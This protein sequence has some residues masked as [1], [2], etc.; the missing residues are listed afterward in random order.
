MNPR[1]YR[2]IV[3]GIKGCLPPCI[4]CS[5]N[6]VRICMKTGFECQKFA[7]YSAV[8]VKKDMASPVARASER[9]CGE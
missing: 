6:Y 4:K 2:F 5:D 7:A 1:E 9:S 8:P 3:T